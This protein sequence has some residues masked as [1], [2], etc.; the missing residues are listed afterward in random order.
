MPI[1]RINAQVF[2]TTPIDEEQLYENVKKIYKNEGKISTAII[3]ERLNVDFS[4]A[5]KLM[6]RVIKEE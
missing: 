2:I 4:L 6:S 3:I 5:L 1:H